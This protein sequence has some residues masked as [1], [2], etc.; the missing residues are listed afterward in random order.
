MFLRRPERRLLV[1]ILREFESHH[2]DTLLDDIK[3]F[4]ELKAQLKK[5]LNRGKKKERNNGSFRG[6]RPLVR[7]RKDSN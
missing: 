2:L 5:S 3:E 4:K 6:K 7:R 1:K